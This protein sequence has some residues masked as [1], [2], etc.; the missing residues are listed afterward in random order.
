MWVRLGTPIL[1]WAAVSVAIGM[2]AGGDEASREVAATA[3]AALANHGVLRRWRWW[4]RNGQ[5]YGCS[6]P[7]NDGV[8]N[9]KLWARGASQITMYCRVR[10]Y[11]WL[12][13]PWS[14]IPHDA[15]HLQHVTALVL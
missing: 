9:N 14:K 1:P 3:Q 12:A 13:A 11:P 4:P 8:R 10:L 7:L 15:R 6:M 5:E 2:L